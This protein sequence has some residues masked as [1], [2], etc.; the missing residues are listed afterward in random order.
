[1]AMG[2]WQW[3][4]GNGVVAMGSRGNGVAWQWGRV[5]KV[6][7]VKVPPKTFYG[8][9]LAAMLRFTPA[10]YSDPTILDPTILM[11]TL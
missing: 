10:L 2:S 4:R 7:G 3:G 6:A 1:M 5:A 8:L 9:T 11:S